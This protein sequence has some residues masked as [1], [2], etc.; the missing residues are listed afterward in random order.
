MG[1]TQQYRNYLFIS[2]AVVSF[3]KIQ[4]TLF[5][6]LSLFT[7]EAQYWLWSRNLDWNYYSKP[8]MIA[9][10]NRFSTFLF[11]HKEFAV[12][13]NAVFFAAGTA[14]V[15]FELAISMFK[16]AKLAYWSSILLLVMP[17]Y[18]LASLFHTTDS[19]LV[20]FWALSI[21][22]IWKATHS[23]RLTYWLLAGIA[24]ALGI[25][26]KNVMVLILPYTLLFL[27][28]KDY[29]QIISGRF[30]VFILIASMSFIPILIWNLQ[31]DW[32]TFRHVGT[33]GGVSGTGQGFQWTDAA[34]F[35]GEYIGG[36]IAVIS[37]FLAPLF[38]LAIKKW[39]STMDDRLLFLLLP[40]V[41][42]WMLF[43][44]VSLV[45]R[46]EVNWPAFVYVSLPI[47]FAYAIQQNKRWLSYT[48][49]ATII[50]GILLILIMYPAPIDAIGFKKVLRPDKDPFARL[51]GYKELGQRVDFLKDSLNLKQHFVFSDTYHVASSLSFY[52]E[53]HPQTYNPNLGR[54][55]N[56]FDLWPGL[57]QFENKNYAGIFVKWGED[58]MPPVQ[59]AFENL[60]HEETLTIHY[61]GTPVRVFLIQ[62]LGNYHYL[63]EVDVQAY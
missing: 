13:I 62:M 50:S 59:E 1:Q 61:R 40:V 25:L 32:V 63:E 55:K 29:R 57:E 9:L 21:L 58:S 41:L 45:K 26:S 38:V 6:P 14:W 51:A 35:M 5:T 4:F 34:K 49:I 7:E 43:L 10:Y 39:R 2:L 33:L 37:V 22:L 53:G 42:T 20:F 15:L 27:L 46:V 24:T 28:I 17:F 36:Q 56:Q 54:R 30:L 16:N 47:A 3:F 12:R 18:H 19:S 23:H 11:G 44:G 48:R 60:L 52:L 31:N 8:L